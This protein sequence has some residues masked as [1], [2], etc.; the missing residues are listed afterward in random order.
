[1]IFIERKAFIEFLDPGKIRITTP[2]RQ[3]EFELK[4][5]QN[6]DLINLKIIS[7]GVGYDKFYAVVNSYE[8]SLSLKIFANGRHLIG[9]IWFVE[10]NKLFKT[11][12]LENDRN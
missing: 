5:H 12:I 7:I 3:K 1:M 2:L 10:N 11:K 8:G 9:E 4:V 6:I